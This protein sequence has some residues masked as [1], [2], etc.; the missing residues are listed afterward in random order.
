[1][2]MLIAGN[3]VESDGRIEVLN[4][5]DDS[6]V[7]TVPQASAEQVEEAIQSA[8]R[9]FEVMRKMPACERSDILNRT[10]ELIREHNDEL[11]TLLA[12]EVGKTLAEGRTEASR[13]AET[14]TLSAEEAK[15][16]HGET[17]PYDAAAHGTNKMGFYIRVP[18]GIVCAIT[19]FNFP[20][21]LAA[22]KVG[23]AI[24][25]GCSMI[26]KPASVTPLA[27]LRMGE[28][29]LEAGLPP[30]AINIVTG[31]GE[32][33]GEALVADERIRKVSFTGSAE[34]GKRIMRI[35]G[36]KKCTMELG[37][38]SA[39]VIMD[40][41]DLSAAADRIKAGGY[42]VAGQVCI[43]TQR[44]LV[45]DGVFDD[46]MAEQLPLVQALAAG[47]QLDEATNVGPM[48]T[49]KIAGETEAQIQQAVDGGA[50]LLC[51][52]ERDGAVVQPAVLLDVPK[53]SFLGCSEAFAPLI[54]VD[55]VSDI[56]EAIRLVND[57]PYGLQAGIYTQNINN[58]FTFIKEAQ[59]GG[60][61]V[62]EVP[63]FRVDGMPYGGVKDSG[64]GR[65]GPRFAIEDMT[66]IR[67][68][69]FNL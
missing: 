43:S 5:F 28:L 3:W 33:V 14:F 2:K 34:V 49:R 64:L 9:G 46:F 35:A 32:T 40:D 16:I 18:I 50:K 52:G 68:V 44:V 61:M 1:M 62:N 57:S 12:Q 63:T 27:D 69:A 17:V 10:A 60:V 65:E 19:P 41:A 47:D 38:N 7:D 48:I 15:R 42:A 59:V 51:G 36:L 37:S 22:H 8:E 4:P 21:N 23:P 20:L 56:D 67:V 54:C 55:R 53:D 45:R 39:V 13:A 25:A 26:L 11:G 24:A 30:E 31:S 58:A 29:L 6:V 66:E